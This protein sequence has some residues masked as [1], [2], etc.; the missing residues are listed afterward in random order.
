MYDYWY[1]YVK[2]K[3]GKKA[4]LY[5][6]NTGSFIVHLASEEIEADLVQDVKKNFDTS[7]YE[8]K[9]QLKKDRIDER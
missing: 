4:K 3:Y 2:P 7:N 5:Y 6:T 1:N 8:V 9:R